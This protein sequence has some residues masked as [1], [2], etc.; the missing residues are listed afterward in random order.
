MYV[1][2]NHTIFSGSWSVVSG[3]VNE[4]RSRES[5]FRKVCWNG[6]QSYHIISLSY[7]PKPLHMSKTNPSD[8]PTLCQ[9]SPCDPF[10]DWSSRGG[11]GWKKAIN[12]STT[13]RFKDDRWAAEMHWFEDLGWNQPVNCEDFTLLF[14][15]LESPG[16]EAPSGCMLR[17]WGQCGTNPFTDRKGQVG[18]GKPIW[19]QMLRIARF[20]CVAVFEEV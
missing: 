17:P 6:W 19:I 7:D 16:G 13:S 18:N 11:F 14:R 3:S 2:W 12:W 1:H 9:L 5:G 4:F 8:F 10:F 20:F 15:M